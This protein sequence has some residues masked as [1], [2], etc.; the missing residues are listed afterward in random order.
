MHPSK[1][2]PTYLLMVATNCCPG[3]VAIVERMFEFAK[4]TETITI[5]EWTGSKWYVEVI[6]QT[7]IAEVEEAKKVLLLPRPSFDTLRRANAIR[8]TRFML[9]VDVRRDCV[10]WNSDGGNCMI[11]GRRWKNF[12]TSVNGFG[13]ACNLEEFHLYK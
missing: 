2:E 3:I 13:A 11:R 6:D 8:A 7:V 1:R 5:H 4:K 10:L 9:S 12:A